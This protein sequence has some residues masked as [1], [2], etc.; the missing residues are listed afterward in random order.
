MIKLTLPRRRA[1]L[2]SGGALAA[3]MLSAGVA[4]AIDDW[5]NKPV[6]YINSFPAGGPTDTLSR[7]VCHEL[8][9]L[10]G[11]QFVVEN[12]AGAGGNVGADV[13]AKSAP[14]G[15]TIGLYSIASHAIAPTLYARLPFDAAKDFTG[16]AMLWSVP[17]MLMVRLDLPAKTVPD[18]IALARDNPGKY[19]FA[20]SGAGTSP[21]ITGE[22]FKQLAKINLLHVPYRGSA[23]AHQDLL[24][25]QVD[26]MFDNIPGPLGLMRSGKVRGLAVTSR[27]RH[28]A[29]PDIPTMAEYL[30]GFEITSWGGVCGPAGLPAPMVEKLSLLTRKALESEAVKKA[31]DQQGATRIWMNPADTAA[32]RAADEK[33]LAPVIRQSG[34]K[35]D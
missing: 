15:Y 22:L 29:A 2:L 14:D 35:V 21:Q 24:A 27:E 7:I 3:P 33:R 13:I 23:P 5:P 18:L 25:G 12:K 20:S 1:L 4:R 8:S 31:F 11:Q 28:P 17:N 6:R 26:M 16:I 10:A 9:Q 34:A 19:S 32:Y 30:P